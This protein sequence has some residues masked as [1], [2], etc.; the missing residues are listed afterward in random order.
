[1][2]FAGKQVV[3]SKGMKAKEINVKLKTIDTF[4]ANIELATDKKAILDLK[5]LYNNEFGKG[6]KTPGKERLSFFDY[7]DE[8]TLSMGAQNDW[9]VATF[10]NLQL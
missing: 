6:D 5:R 10:E 1:M 2:T 3:N 8:F 7:Y 9:T 4:F